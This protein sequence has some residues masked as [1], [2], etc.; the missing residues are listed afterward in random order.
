MDHIVAVID[1]SGSMS[2]IK[3]DAEGGINSFL[4][5]QKEI[6]EAKLTLA[7][8]DSEY[9]LLHEG[10]DIKLFE[11]Y[12]LMPRSMTALYDAVGMT[13]ARVKDDKVSGKRIFV[14]VTDGMENASREWNKTKV[15][16]IISEMKKDDWEFIFL[17]ASEEALKDSASWGM[18][19]QTSFAF[20]GSSKGVNDGYSAIATYSTA[21]RSGASKKY[22]VSNLDKE[23]KTS[24]TLK[25]GHHNK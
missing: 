7:E 20:D 4:Q 18:D 8:F 5:N 13:A 22:A 3:D 21:I 19:A 11:K 6:G 24:G 23:I 25:K 16:E 12:T 1:R 10:T 15:I 2:I 17:A 14:I 9:N